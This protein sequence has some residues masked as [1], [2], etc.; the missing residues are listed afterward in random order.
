MTRVIGLGAGGHAKVVADILRLMGGFEIHGILDPRPAA[1][2]A[3]LGAPL[4][5]DDSRLEEL[6]ASGVRHVFVGVGGATDPRR[7]QALFDRAK[8]AGA[9]FV[10]AIHP[11]AVVADSASIGD[12]PTIMA[13]AIVNAAARLGH[14]VIVNTGAIVEHDCELGDHVHVATGARLAGGVKVGAAAH[15]G[16]GAT[17]IQGITIGEGALVGAGAV[18]VR[19][20]PPRTV[21]VGVPARAL[22]S[23]T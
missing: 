11:Q 14:N 9:E 10:A 20:V 17:I 2:L 5:G 7:R 3:D 22:R 6:I 16:I 12:G 1:D 13:G 21:V 18:V 8:I 19:D 15:I 23:T 4:L